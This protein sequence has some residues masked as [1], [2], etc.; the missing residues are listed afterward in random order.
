MEKCLMYNHMYN[1][2]L[3]IDAREGGSWLFGYCNAGNTSTK[4]KVNFGFIECWLNKDGISN[5]FSIP[6]LEEMMFCITYYSWDVNYIFHAKDG[7]SNSKRMKWV[8]HTLTPKSRTW[9]SYKPS[10]RILKV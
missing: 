5:I 2:E 8:Y 4:N 10:R 1:E 7:G 3:L 6:I 9:H